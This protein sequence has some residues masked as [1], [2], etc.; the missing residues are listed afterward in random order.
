MPYHL[1]TRRSRFRS[2]PASPGTRGSRRRCRCRCSRPGRSRRPSRCHACRGCCWCPC[3][4]RAIARVAAR[5][6]SVTATAS[7]CGIARLIVA[8]APRSASL[9]S[10]PTAGARSLDVG[11]TRRLSP[12]RRPVSLP[13][14]ERRIASTRCPLRRFRPCCRDDSRAFIG[15]LPR[16]ATP[17]RCP[18]LPAMRNYGSP[19][20]GLRSPKRRPIPLQTAHSKYSQLVAIVTDRC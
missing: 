4:S 17:E 2:A 10:C 19:A 13:Q 11:A 15:L 1:G 8:L 3:S 20:T 9:R 6:G 5:F 12:A 18:T 16:S 7:R 14:R